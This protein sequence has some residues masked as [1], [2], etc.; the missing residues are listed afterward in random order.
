MVP[1]SNASNKAWSN[2]CM[3]SSR[4]RRMASLISPTSP[5]TRGVHRPIDSVAPGKICRDFDELMTALQNED[6][7]KTEAKEMLIDK[8]RTSDLFASDK[9]IDFVLLGKEVPG[10]CK[11]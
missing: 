1:A 2:V 3:P 6:Y 10:I 7:G 9:V 11:K 4:L 5:S 8:C